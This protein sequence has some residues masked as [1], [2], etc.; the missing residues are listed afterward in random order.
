MTLSS[1]VKPVELSAATAEI[2][3]W[4]LVT[5]AGWGATYENGSFSDVLRKTEIRTIDNFQCGQAYGHSRI[6]KYMLCTID[7]GK[8]TCDVSI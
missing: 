1:R 8:D 4:S 6:T 3:P 2:P 7:Y 5:V